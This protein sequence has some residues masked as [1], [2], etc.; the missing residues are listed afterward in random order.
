[1]PPTLT[2][3]TLLFTAGALALV[4]HWP[5]VRSGP[6]GMSLAAEVGITTL[7][8]FALLSGLLVAAQHLLR[9]THA[10]SSVLT[11]PTRSPRPA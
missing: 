7:V 3:L 1:M 2:L 9:R 11:W 4:L 8:L 6:T 10:A 5:R